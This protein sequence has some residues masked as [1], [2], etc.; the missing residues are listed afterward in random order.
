VT[1]EETMAAT[2]R[3]LRTP[4]LVLAGGSMIVTGAAAA[5]TADDP[6]R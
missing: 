2:G 1:E 4:C 5:R 3:C 6:V